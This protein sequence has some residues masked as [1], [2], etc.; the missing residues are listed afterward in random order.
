M[1]LI[2]MSMMPDPAA[3]FA[4]AV[5]RVEEAAGNGAQIV[6]LP[7]LFRLR[8]FCQKEDPALFD[9]AEPL[10]GPSSESVRKARRQTGRG[11]DR[12]RV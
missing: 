4:K 11:G 1:A 2:Q 7:E 3:N 6:C 10:P 9:L 12:A 8:Y 5:V